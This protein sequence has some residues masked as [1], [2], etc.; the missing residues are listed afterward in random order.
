[1]YNLVVFSKCMEFLHFILLVFC[2]YLTLD[3]PTY[4]KFPDDQML[5]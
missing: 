4:Y 1:M 2:I 3:S 5:C